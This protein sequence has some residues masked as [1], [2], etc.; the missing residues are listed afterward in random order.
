MQPTGVAADSAGLIAE[1]KAIADTVR[2]TFGSLRAAELTWQP[3]AGEWS[4]AQCFEHLILSN[5]VYFPILG[6]IARGEWRPTLKE[7]LP[8]LPKLFGKAVLNA[9]QPDTRR[10]VKAR[11]K[12]QP[13][14]GGIGGDIIDRFLAHQ[15][16]LC[17]H[18][19][20]TAGCDWHKTIITSPVISFMTYSLFDAYR[21]I[22]THEEHHLVQA[23]RVVDAPGFPRVA[24]TASET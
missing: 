2:R 24:A 8:L 17:R 18:V 5:A 9:V 13:S 12:F 20:V 1:L 15:Q 21:I 19:Q 4:I 23:R 16:E 22:V 3:V 14:S 7:R 6:R 10:R 11:P